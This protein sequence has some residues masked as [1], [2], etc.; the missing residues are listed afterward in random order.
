MKVAII[1][2]FWTPVKGGVTSVVVNLSRTLQYDGIDVIVVAWTGKRENGVYAFNGSKITFIFK[3]LFVLYKERPD[4]LH[5][6]S[7]WY[8]LLPCVIYKT[9]S[10]NKRLI[11]TFHTD[12]NTEELSRVLDRIKRNIFALLLNRADAITFVSMNMAE[13]FKR[14]VSLNTQTHVI[15]NGV[16]KR[17]VN[18]RDV[19]TFKEQYLLGN[20]HPIVS[21][22]GPFS[23]KEKIDGLKLLMETFK[24]V[25]LKYPKSKLL[26]VGDGEFRDDLKIF[27]DILG[28]NNNVI[29]TGFME[30]VFIPFGVTDIYAHIS[31]KDSMPISILEAMSLGKPV[32]ALPTGGIPEIVL[33]NQTGI[34]VKPDPKLIADVLTKLYE[35]EKYMKYLGLNAKKMVEKRFN[36]K[37]VG[38]KFIQVYCSDGE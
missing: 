9:L 13:K 30:N 31:F 14:I 16:S 32:I 17:N 35:D 38:K 23:H 8:T 12:P 26:I 33:D 25:I 2:P 37:I 34:L 7:W 29:F 4:V 28:I 22:I 1:T 10:F 36:W 24:D 15:Y 6:H 5:S 21:W 19:K 27:A 3:T 20:C 18:E 11:H